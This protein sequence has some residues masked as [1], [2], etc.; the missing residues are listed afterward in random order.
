MPQAD[1]VVWKISRRRFQAAIGASSAR[2]RSAVVDFLKESK[3]LAGRDISQVMELA[4]H[5]DVLQWTSG[6]TIIGQGW[7]P[8]VRPRDDRISAIPR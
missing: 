4:E 7:F 1:A 6:S 5:V 2:D 8:E 3:V